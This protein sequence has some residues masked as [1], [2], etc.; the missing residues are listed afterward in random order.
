MKRIGFPVLL[1]VRAGGAG[2][3]AAQG[4]A[5][6]QFERCRTCHSTDGTR[7]KEGPTLK[8]LFGRV[9]GSVDGFDYSPA[10]KDAKIVWTPETLDRFLQ[11]PAKM[12]PGTKML[13]M[14][15]RHPD[16]RAALVEFL[17]KTLG[18]AK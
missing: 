8:G 5:E 7:R 17:G 10:M 1:A 15:I 13:F 16:D 3:A 11:R 9:S 18:T 6:M 2:P 12:V 4:M 14:G